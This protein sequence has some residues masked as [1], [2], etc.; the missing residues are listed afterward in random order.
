MIRNQYDLLGRPTRT[1]VDLAEVDAGITIEGTRQVDRSFDALGRV[2]SAANEVCTITTRFD[3]LGHSIAED[4][5]TAGAPSFQL[6]RRFDDAG[7]LIGLTYPNGRERPSGL[8]SR[9]DRADTTGETS[10]NRQGPSLPSA[11]ADW[12]P[13]FGPPGGNASAEHQL[14]GGVY[15]VIRTN[16]REID[17]AAANTRVL[18]IQSSP[19]YSPDKIAVENLFIPDLGE[20]KTVIE[21]RNAVLRR[22][23]GY[24]P[25]GSPR[26]ASDRICS[27]I[28]KAHDEGIR[29]AAR[30]LS[31][32]GPI[33]LED[34][35]EEDSLDPL[36][37]PRPPRPA[38]PDEA[39]S[40]FPS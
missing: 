3:S 12:A 10:G 38:A 29:M 17:R 22:S 14:P 24:T 35:E 11:P 37:S 23:F 9:G 18:D 5:T 7:R 26:F 27:G 6:A 16:D 15:Y 31:R 25:D 36:V 19:G 40:Q 21:R 20:L 4:T 30:Q 39:P 34:L 8:A 28:E 32:H 2:S 13:N 33:R 1:L